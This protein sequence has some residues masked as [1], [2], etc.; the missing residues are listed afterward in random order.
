MAHILQTTFSFV[1]HRY[2]EYVVV[3]LAYVWIIRIAADGLEPTRH[4]IR[5]S[6]FLLTLESL[7]NNQK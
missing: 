1:H 7:I 5:S 2:V 6:T 4:R 3:L